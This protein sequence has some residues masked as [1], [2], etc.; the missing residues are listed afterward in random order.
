MEPKETVSK[1]RIK[2][3]ELSDITQLVVLEKS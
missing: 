3:G 1:L 2:P